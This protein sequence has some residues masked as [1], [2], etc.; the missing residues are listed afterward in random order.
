MN[1]NVNNDLLRQGMSI[2]IYNFGQ[3][4]FQDVNKIKLFD[5]N[6]L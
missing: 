2:N 5:W 1:E 3:K 4:E 6:V